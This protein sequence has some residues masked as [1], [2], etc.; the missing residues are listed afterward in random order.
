MSRWVGL[1]AI[2]LLVASCQGASDG[3]TASSA[4]SSTSVAALPPATQA[5]ATT[6][7]VETTVPT[8]ATP[9]VEADVDVTANGQTVTCDSRSVLVAGTASPMTLLGACT[10]VIVSGT[11]LAIEIESVG[12]LTVGGSGNAVKVGSV[13]EIHTSGTGN[14]V[15]WAAGSGGAGEP[16]IETTGAGNVVEHGD[17]ELTARAQPT[18]TPPSTAPATSASST[19]L[20]SPDT[21][22]AAR[23]G[24]VLSCQGVFIGSYQGSDAG[25]FR[26]VMGPNGELTANYA[27]T[28]A[29]TN[30]NLG[31][32]QVDIEPDGKLIV[33]TPGVEIV[34]YPDGRGEVRA[35]GVSIGGDFF[36]PEQLTGTI[37]DEG[38]ITLTGSGLSATGALD[39]ETCNMSG[40]W[41]G[42]TWQTGLQGTM[43]S[44]GEDD[45]RD[46]VY[47][48]SGSV[49]ID[50][51]GVCASRLTLDLEPADAPQITEKGITVAEGDGVTAFTL[52]S[53]I[54]FDF[55]SAELRP[56]AEPALDQVIA[57][58][59]ERNPAA[60]IRVIGHTDSIGSDADNLELSDERAASVAAV[61]NDDGRLSDATV[62]ESGVGEAQPVAPNINADG[63]D[64]PE[65]RA[66]NRRVEIVVEA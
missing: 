37:D 10:E 66:R 60:S 42:G 6:E 30:I 45:C 47:V 13:G 41:D 49:E 52:T 9:P 23:T 4:A 21:T 31:Q 22:V 19:T 58:I 28:G 59:A 8:T 34:L 38:N 20:A 46:G 33:T 18:T 48:G 7:T 5:P 64:N 29:L 32:T 27:S 54:L 63:S 57:A 11:A 36:V 50:V 24:N 35:G 55:G 17:V 15:I 62:V 39:V 53:Q 16:L 56:D 12:S 43:V 40:T 3:G 26:I 51:D 2:C 61:L 44:I 14:S 1:V 65:G 25:I